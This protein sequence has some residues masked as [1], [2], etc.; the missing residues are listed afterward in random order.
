SDQ[1]TTFR[2]ARKYEFISNLVGGKKQFELNVSEIKRLEYGLS[3]LQDTY[4]DNICSDD[5]EKHQQ[6]LQLRNTKLELES[7]LRD[8]QRRLKLLDISIEF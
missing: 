6:K 3:H 4:Q 5:I 2:N 8:K 7:I 1:L